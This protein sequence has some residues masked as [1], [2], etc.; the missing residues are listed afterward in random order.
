MYSIL[1]IYSKQHFMFNSFSHVETSTQELRCVGRQYMGHGC[2]WK[3]RPY[4]F[5][6]CGSIP[7]SHHCRKAPQGGTAA[8]VN[9]YEWYMS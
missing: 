2:Q 3:C 9:H 8:A 1:A 7:I 5:V 6:L 4:P